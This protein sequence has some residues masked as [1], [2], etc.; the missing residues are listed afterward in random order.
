[1]NMLIITIHHEV[2]IM[3]PKMINLYKINNVLNKIC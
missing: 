3:K 1:M 2:L